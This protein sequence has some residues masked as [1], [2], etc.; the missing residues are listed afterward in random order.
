MEEKPKVRLIEAIPARK[1][2]E[3]LFIL[4]DPEGFSERTIALSERGMFIAALF[5]GTRTVRDVQAAYVRRFGDI[6]AAA[7]IENI[8]EELD[9][10]M[11]LESERFRNAIEAEIRNYMESPI[12]PARHA[13]TAY[14]PDML[15]L[16][17]M[18]K[19]C[20]EEKTKIHSAEGI[21]TGI[22]SPHIDMNRGRNCY[23]AL[24]GSLSE[25]KAANEVETVVIFGTCHFPMRSK[26][27]LTEKSFDTPM[28]IVETDGDAVERIKAYMNMENN[29]YEIAHKNEHSIEIQLPLL[30]W[31][32][33]GSDR[34]KIVPVLCEGFA[35]M[36]SRS[37]SP[38]DD[39]EI[40]AM[41]EAVREIFES[42]KKG[43]VMV[44]A[45]ADLAHVGPQ[46]GDGKALNQ[47]MIDIVEVKDRRSVE[48]ACRL[49]AEAFYEEIMIEADAR[50]VC[51][52]PPIYM[53]LESMPKGSKGE[54]VCYDKWIDESG[55]GAV[56]F[57][58]A[59]FTKTPDA[60]PIT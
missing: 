44:V 57:A 11:F 16:D 14:P 39:S 29:G 12:R 31:L 60:L 21:L 46:F 5:D 23:S 53:A 25:S 42:R 17:E 52:L 2:N 20:G 54:L 22:I 34:F 43:S 47:S 48:F 6:V 19:V 13:G 41:T 4:R 37:E 40:E 8:A 36:I 24:Y 28:G 27:A 59:V 35:E 32:F 7:D 50:H 30:I 33:G 38:K 10:A 56:T 51:G 18:L 9:N 45:A 55:N 3:Q 15:S 1:G 58:G 26:F 49:D